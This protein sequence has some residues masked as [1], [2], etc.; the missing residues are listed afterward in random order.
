[1]PTFFIPS[2]PPKS[3]HQ[4]SAMILHRKDGSAFVGKSAS[5]KGA[6]VKANLIDLLRPC[7][8]ETP[9]SG[10]VR[11]ILTWTYPWRKTEPKKTRAFGWKYCETRPDID[12]LLKMVKDVMTLLGYW[13][14]DSQVADLRFVKGWGNRAGIGVTLEPCGDPT[15]VADSVAPDEQGELKL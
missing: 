7:A 12:N 15:V 4:G 5:S 6:A 13:R 8:P 2:N 11:L 10:P 1:M 14:D 9:L 3:T